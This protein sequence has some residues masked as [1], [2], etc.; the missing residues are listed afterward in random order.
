M[1]LALARMLIHAIQ[2]VVVDFVDDNDARDIIVVAKD[3]SDYYVGH[4][5]YDKSDIHQLRSDYAEFDKNIK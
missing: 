1:N 4:D 2:N 3:I 5:I